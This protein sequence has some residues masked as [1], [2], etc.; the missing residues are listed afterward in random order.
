M[1][2]F[3]HDSEGPT[4]SLT[5]SCLKPGIGFAAVLDETPSHFPTDIDFKAFNLIAGPLEATAEK[6]KKW[7]ITDY[8]KV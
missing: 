8:P 5:L 1:K 4:I 3:L 7:W 6:G 2:R